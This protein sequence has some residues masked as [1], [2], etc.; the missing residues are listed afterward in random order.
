[1]GG[2]PGG[3]TAAELVVEAATSVL[4]AY[5]DAGRGS[6]DWSPDDADGEA[7]QA[8]YEAVRRAQLRVGRGQQED[9]HYRRMGATLTL[10]LQSGPERWLVANV[11]DSPAW[12]VSA[13]AS[14]QVTEDHN[15]AG[16]LARRGAISSSQAMA[17]PGRHV[18]SRVIGAGGELTPAWWAI[19]LVAGEVLVLASDGLSLGVDTGAL[20]ELM[21]PMAGSPAA[22]QAQ[23]MIDLAL[24]GGPSDNVTVI[25][26]RPLTVEE[27]PGQAGDVR[28]GEPAPTT[29]R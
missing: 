13:H 19:D 16:E 21:A 4:E 8:V 29:D 1:M 26:I 7:V 20:H 2:Y 27:S 5:R 24:A 11:G 14:Y 18:L 9:P 17:H 10:A 23:G 25:V 12:V 22:T 6:G 3:A 15:L 28:S